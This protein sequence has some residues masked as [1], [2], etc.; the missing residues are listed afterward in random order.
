M[1]RLV[2][3]ELF[4]NSA[5]RLGRRRALCLLPADRRVAIGALGRD[6]CFADENDDMPAGKHLREMLALAP[7][8]GTPIP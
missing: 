7:R 3:A 1:L 4:G 6:S 5:V 8:D 2:S